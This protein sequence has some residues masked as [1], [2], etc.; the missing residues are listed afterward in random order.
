MAGSK[1]EPIG[2][3]HLGQKNWDRTAEKG[4]SRQVGLTGQ[5]WKGR[6]GHDSK[7]GQLQQRQ[8]SWGMTDGIEQ[9]G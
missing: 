7:K 6:S 9:L 3:E 2:T 1:T 4:Q 8:E 5:E